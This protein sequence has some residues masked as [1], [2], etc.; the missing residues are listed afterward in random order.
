M[1]RARNART[2]NVEKDFVITRFVN[3]C[4]YFF[5]LGAVF[6]VLVAIGLAVFLFS[7]LDDEI[8]RQAE[9]YLADQLPHFNVSIGGARLVEGQG[10]AIYDLA[11][12]ETSSTQLQSNL[13]IVDEIM[14]SCDA[15][16]TKLVN[17]LPDV[18]R[19]LV[20]HPQVWAARSRDGTW[21]WKSFLDSLPECDRKK[22][23]IIIENAQLTLADQSRAGL[24]PLSLRDVHLRIH[25][26]ADPTSSAEAAAQ[27]IAVK[28]SFGGPL[29]EVAELE[30]YCD[31]SNS[32]IS[33][34]TSF[35]SLEVNKTLLAWATAYAGESLQQTKLLGK[36]DGRVTVQHSLTSK[37][38]PQVSANLQLRDARI[39]DARLP[40]PVVDL[41]C[42]VEYQNELLSIKGLQAM[43]GSAS[44]GLQLDRRGWASQ[45]PMAV[46]MR[47]ENVTLDEQLYSALP[48]VLQTEWAK[49]QPTGVVDAQLQATFDGQRWRPTALITGRDLQFESDKFRYRV[50]DG[51][52]TLRFTPRSDKQPNTLD[53]DLIG[54]AGGQPL[55]FVGQVYDPQPGAIGSIAITG[56]NIKIEDRMI[57]ALPG[58]TRDVIESLHPQGRFNLRWR[59]NR[60]QVGQKPHTS[61][62]MDL[63]DCQMNYD[64]F[65]YPLSGIRGMVQAEDRN[66]AFRDLVATGSRKVRCQGTLRP[67]GPD[68]AEGNEL[69]LHLTG[70]Q[71]P[72]DEDL[73]RALPPNVGRAWLEL[74]P[75]GDIDLRAEINHI[76]G[77]P[78]PSIG[79]TINPRAES[80]SIE[81]N[82]FPYL[83]E[84]QSGR[85]SYQ[86]GKVHMAQIRAR[87]GQTKMLTNGDGE[88]LEDGS[89][90]V[91]L[92][93]LAVEKLTQL[94][95][96]TDALPAQ[97]RSIIE[98]LRPSGGFALFKSTLA[99]SKAA[100]RNSP[101]NAE[102]DI[103]LNCHQ[104]NIQAGIELNNIHGAVRLVGAMV[105]GNSHSAGELAIEN[106]TFQDIQFT[107]IKGPLW[108]DRGR[109]LF[110]AHA[111]NQLQQPIRRLTARVY[112][113]YVRADSW[114]SFDVVPKY[115][116]TAEVTGADLSRIMRERINGQ[117][118]Y[119]GKLNA[120]L[121][122]S[123]QGRSLATMVGHGQVQI[124]DANI[125][126]LPI[127]VSMLSVL[128]NETPTTTAFTDVRSEYRIQGPHIYLDQLDFKGDAVSLLGRGET[129]FDH[130]LRLEF[131]PVV[132]RDEIQL[133]LV[134]HIVRGAG[135]QTLHMSVTGTL[136]DPQVSTQPLPGINNLI[137]QLELAPTGTTTPR[138]AER[139]DTAWPR[140][141]LQ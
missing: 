76:S 45:A 128:R 88:F 31:P 29:V 100:N 40:R 78:K 16:L 116:A 1:G 90:R 21:N 3:I 105:D 10:I 111:T 54:Y 36:V 67:R 17:G 99:F 68:P 9:Q 28:G 74:R 113:G 11:I 8:R 41:N 114:V 108:V 46:A 118:D 60:K 85:F 94:R 66:W 139:S 20:R 127:L 102:W 25:P 52:G 5:R 57:E 107:D 109:C 70:D 129:N 30:A 123:G 42:S 33:I 62:Q 121:T 110:G 48:P 87:H 98:Y 81:P 140:R 2:T 133:P 112:K 137:K 106:A 49:Y 79:I 13:L 24:P 55:K 27:P 72:F 135:R 124:T 12:S 65:P 126:Q 97:L 136:S 95:D 75:R 120:T 73:R 37:S 96:L 50:T 71:I 80:T 15:K 115:H 44:V 131:E 69:H 86:D 14:F 23:E 6:A 53:I 61:L 26:Q 93:G 38:R 138:N 125:Y 83:M 89:W 91:R 92:D 35:Q 56:E 82:F 59:L 39:E 134:K 141:G 18:R 51:S 4:W 104:A 22:P 7:R 101:V 58:K 132:G 119:Q 64:K 43:C 84:L 77:S 122:L 63:L 47:L 130:Q 19:V 117:L 103:K 34:S 32:S